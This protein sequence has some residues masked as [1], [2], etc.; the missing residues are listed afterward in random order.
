MKLQPIF[1]AVALCCLGAAHA[2]DVRRPYI[3]QL[4]DKPVSTYTGG[5]SG[6][7][8][9]RP[10]AGQQLDLSAPNVQLY[11]QYLAQKQGSL[12]A[13]IAN[14]PVQYQFQLALNGFA[15]MLTDDEVRQLKARS[16]VAAISADAP[17]HLVTNYTTSFLGLDQANGLWSQLGGKQHAGE[18]IIIGVLDTGVVPENLSYSDRLDVNGK[19]TWDGNASLAYDAPPARWRGSCESGAGFERSYCNNKLIGAQYFA[20]GFLDYAPLDWTEFLSPR[21]SHGHGTHTSTTAAGNRDVPAEVY[22]VAMPANAGMAP[23]ARLAAYKVCWTG[24]DLNGRPFNSCMASDSV[25][26][27]EKAISD[28]VNVINYSISGGQTLDDPVDLAFLHAASAGVFVAAAGGNEGPYN[29]TLSH[30]TPWLTTVAA[31][32]HGQQQLA[33]LTLGNGKQYRGLSLNQSALPQTSLVLAE[34]AAL[35]GV[36]PSLARLCPLVDPYT[37]EALTVLDPAKVK[38]KIV[39]CRR[40][41]YPV[42]DKAQSVKNAGGVAMVLLD[43]SQGGFLA[44]YVLPTLH[45]SLEDGTAITDYARSGR[46]MA[47]L[48]AFAHVNGAAPAP[49]VAEFS[50]RGPNSLDPNVLKPDLAAPG[51]DIL[52]GIAP[53]LSEEQHAQVAAGTLK[54]PTPWSFWAGTSM[55]TPHVAGIAAL[56]RQQHPDWS[57]AAIKS[58]LMTTTRP[59]VADN[60][61]DNRSSA[62]LGPGGPSGT[63]PWGQGAGQIVPNSATDPGL[64]YDLGSADYAKYLCGL[65]VTAQCGSG[66]IMAYN[67]NLPS[68]TA[69][70]AGYAITLSRKVTNVGASRA[71]YNARASLP[72]FDVTVSPATLTL[73]P[74]ESASF[75]VA[76]KRTTAPER[77]WQYGALS[78]SDG[79]HSVTS[80]LQASTGYLIDAPTP[81][82]AEKASGLR[83]L[84]VYTGYSGKLA[85][86]VGGMKPVSRA[87]YEVAQ[88]PFNS[89]DTKEQIVAACN[90][91]QA[92]V[93]VIP[94]AIPAN[95]LAAR[96]ELFNRDTGDGGNHDLDLAVFGVNGALMELSAK[97][98]SDESI[99]LNSP[100]AGTYRVCV[101][102]NWIANNR[103]TG[104]QLSSA[105]VT[106]ADNNGTLK[107]TLPTK[108]YAGA[109]ATV[110]VS[111]SGLAPQQR[112]FGVLQFADGA[113]TVGSTTAVSI[114]TGN[115]VPLPPPLS[116]QVRTQ[117]LKA[118]L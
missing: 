55:A 12:L 43:N 20:K 110:G 67:L 32:T 57:P 38:G 63:L 14:A 106:P 23:R 86:T 46:G 114:D 8:A 3:V 68:L 70:N 24:V 85:T 92:G 48:S 88:A 73:A 10:A 83:A 9:T 54:S 17:R 90:A 62:P 109:Y 91:G 33:T 13:T 53:E 40:G 77:Q 36:A 108:V 113:G 60:V 76:L 52:S 104:F 105:I 51:V 25:A 107:V 44:N 35:P 103:S 112:Y 28:G 100:L 65:G 59:T 94:V 18:D 29:F 27:I 102:G 16:D 42:I 84:S 75:N 87:S 1:I 82:V 26:A 89:V 78:W 111:W 7:Q 64:V 61:T 21:D 34:D 56:L 97:Q 96:F 117:R 22:G 79:S 95:T 80:P 41:D 39:L 37:E 30:M 74:G 71:T 4:A 116:K 6:I 69:A 45:V 31:T 66:S 98:G 47:A 49:M 19:P 2:D 72:G 50:S 11:S 93:R 118:P 15:A 58:A 5:V 81:V 115:P 101:I 99:T